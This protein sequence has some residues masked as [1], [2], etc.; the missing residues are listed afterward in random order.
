MSHVGLTIRIVAI[1]F[2][3]RETEPGAASAMGVSGVGT[4]G[5]TEGEAGDHSQGSVRR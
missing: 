2:S 4:N 1:M 3:V 5:A